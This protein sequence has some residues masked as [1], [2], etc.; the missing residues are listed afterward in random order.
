MN[1]VLV[2][3]YVPLLGKKYDV[4]IPSHR[5]IYNVI[6]LLVEAINDLNDDCYN[7][8]QTPLLYDKLT[9]KPYDINLSVKESTIRNGTEVVLI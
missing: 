3:L 6:S 4:K 9:A 7:P 1:E 2:R 8:K 5:R